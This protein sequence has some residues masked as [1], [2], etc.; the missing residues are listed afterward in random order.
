MEAINNKGIWTPL[1]DGLELKLSCSSSSS[2]QLKEDDELGVVIRS[3]AHW[4][5]ALSG[6]PLAARQ[7][8]SLEPLSVVFGGARVEY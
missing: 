4:Y 7:L 6:L 5:R 2:L 3:L 8:Q 1:A